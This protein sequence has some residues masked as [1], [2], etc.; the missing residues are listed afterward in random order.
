M[1]LVLALS[2]FVLHSY[3]KRLFYTKYKSNI[4]SN[5][6]VYH[7]EGGSR[8]VR[9]TPFGLAPLWKILNLP[10]PNV[11]SGSS[12]SGYTHRAGYVGP[13]CAGD[14]PGVRGKG[15]AGEAAL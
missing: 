10:L 4:A 3:A 15:A 9:R 11:R 14:L 13:L 5:L 2:G 6:G 1:Y 12:A 7:C 8:I